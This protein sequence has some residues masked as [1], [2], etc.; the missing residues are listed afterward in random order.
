MKTRRSRA[1]AHLLAS[2]S[3]APRAVAVLL[4]MIVISGGALRGVAAAQP[5]KA[6][7]SQDAS[8]YAKLGTSLAGGHYT[9]GPANADDLRWPP[10]APFFFA[11]AALLTPSSPAAGEPT[12]L[13]AAYWLQAIVSTVTLALVFVL[14]ALLAGPV[15]GL[16]ASALVA[17][18]PPLIAINGS[19]MSETLGAFLATSAILFIVLALRAR[20]WRFM[21][22]AG[23]AFGL[24]VLTRTDFLF[25]IAAIAIAIALLARRQGRGAGLRQAGAFAAAAALVIAPWTIYA[26]G[27]QGRL[28][29]VT[30]GSGPVLFTGTYLPGDGTTVGLK[31]AFEPELRKRHPE[32][33]TTKIHK[34]PAK[35]VMSLVASRHPEL[36]RDGALQLEGRRNLVEYGLG[37][38]IDFAAMTLSKVERMWGKYY[39]G[40]GVH[41]ISAVTRSYQWLLVALAV[42]GLVA[43]LARRRFTGPFAV[44]FGLA[45]Y[46]TLL[47]AVVV[48]QA[49]YNLPL[50]PM[51]VAGGVAALAI[52][53][54]GSDPAR[55]RSAAAGR[56]A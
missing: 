46:S 48:S 41:Y 54:A 43:L 14:A 56:H 25:A 10:G 2:R 21:A 49:R 11:A 26:S 13:P 23:V 53:A 27:R 19:L 55:E 42:C 32:F 34:I 7:V 5:D 17:F 40:G 15:A 29:P 33:R 51:L 50:M 37:D 9:Q 36:S 22:L 30:T 12:D 45:L 8:A 52:A 1:I 44:L 4:A 39:R 16:V 20:S 47:H 28:V 18:Y 3:L 31:K 6:Y 38:P 24:L 35:Y